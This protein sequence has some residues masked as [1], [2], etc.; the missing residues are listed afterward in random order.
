M[1]F[2][3]YQAGGVEGLA[4]ETGGGSFRG[5]LKSSPDFPGTL[6]DIVRSGSFRSAADRLAKGAAVDLDS[7][8]FLPPLRRA[9]KILYRLEDVERWLAS[10]EQNPEGANNV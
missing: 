2:L 10:Q 7:V 3:G 5:L 4:V 6:D 9:G 8:G 1:R